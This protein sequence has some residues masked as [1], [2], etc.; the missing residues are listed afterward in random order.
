[1]KLESAVFC[2]IFIQNAC[3]TCH[4][5][6]FHLVKDEKGKCLDTQNLRKDKS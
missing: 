5:F 4:L 6:Y 3:Y 2:I 1:M